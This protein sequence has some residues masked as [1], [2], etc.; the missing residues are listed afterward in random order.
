MA[1]NVTYPRRRQFDAVVVNWSTSLYGPY[2]FDLRVI[3]QDVGWTTCTFK[4]YPPDSGPFAPEPAEAEYLK[5]AAAHKEVVRI[6]AAVCGD[7]HEPP[8]LDERAYLTDRPRRW[9]LILED[10]GLISGPGYEEDSDE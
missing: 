5:R 3:G 10:V 9:G 6:D 7:W 2:E 8:P 1:R 4:V